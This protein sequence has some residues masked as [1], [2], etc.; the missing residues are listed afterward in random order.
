MLW[1]LP[2]RTAEIRRAGRDGLVRPKAVWRL[3]GARRSA[4]DAGIGQ[5]LQHLPTYFALEHTVA[6]QIIRDIVPESGHGILT[7]MLSEKTSL[8]T[9]AWA[10]RRLTEQMVSVFLYEGA[11]SEQ[12]RKP[13][14]GDM[15]DGIK[16][17]CGNE[18][19]SAIRQI[20]EIGDKASHYS[21][22][23]VTSRKDVERTVSLTLNLFSMI[24][25]DRCKSQKLLRG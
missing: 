17:S 1:P 4:A 6:E 13:S 8:Q 18:I 20:N 22:E 25:T 5:E 23:S 21:G 11:E 2:T 12:S 9:K 7:D 19:L 3:S 24:S 14:L 15:I 16:D 10:A